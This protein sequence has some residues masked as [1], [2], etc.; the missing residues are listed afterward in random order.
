MALPEKKVESFIKEVDEHLL[1]QEPIKQKFL[2]DLK[3]D[4]TEFVENNDVNDISSVY[5]Q[6]G[7]PD[8][9][10]RGFL[11]SVDPK[12][13][14][15]ATKWKKVL[16]IGVIVALMSLVIYMVISFIDGHSRSTGYYGE[17]T[18]HEKIDG[19]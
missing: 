12:S 5:N 2:S 9:I 8:E 6:F 15:K 18:V 14:K 10:A 11:D 19:G 17:T 16:I 1:C 7:K 3:N 13:I 4:I